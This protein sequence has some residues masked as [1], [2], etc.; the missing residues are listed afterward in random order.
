MDLSIYVVGNV[1][2]VVFLLFPVWNRTK[3]KDLPKAFIWLMAAL[4]AIQFG[5]VLSAMPRRHVVIVVNS[6][7]FA[8]ATI[9]LLLRIGWLQCTFHLENGLDRYEKARHDITL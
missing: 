6:L 7:L 4:I 2:H 9:L 8:V 5:M 1:V 3:L